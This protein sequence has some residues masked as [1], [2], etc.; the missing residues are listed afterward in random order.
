MAIELDH[1][2]LAVNDLAHSTAFYSQMLGL[3]YE[4][5]R[6][7]VRPAAGLAGL[8]HPT[9]ALGHRRW[10]E[11]LAFALSEAEFDAAFARIRAAGIPYGDRFDAVGNMQG[12][13]RRAGRARSRARRSIS[14]IPTSI[15]WKSGITPP[16]R[17]LPAAP[18]GRYS[19]PALRLVLPRPTPA[20]DGAVDAL[21]QRLALGE[22]AAQI[23]EQRLL[24]AGR[25]AGP[26]VGRAPAAPDSGYRRSGHRP[27]VSARSA[28]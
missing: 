14:S 10:L 19:A 13:G 9:S 17:V 5:E 3:G 12:A 24:V 16:V 8:R 20:R 23:E 6:R 28:L 4:G 26:A 15:C 2:I 1:I 25:I 21:D 22:V 11:H 7:A 27:A 18:P